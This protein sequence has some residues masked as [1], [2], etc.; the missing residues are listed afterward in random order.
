[1]TRYYDHNKIFVPALPG[2]EKD[3]DQVLSVA[4]QQRGDRV[5]QAYLD[6]DFKGGEN[7]ILVSGGFNP[8]LPPPKRG[9]RLLANYLM[10]AYNIDDSAILIED[11]ST[12]IAEHFAFSLEDYET[13]FNDVRFGKGRKRLAIAS[14][15]EHLDNMIISGADALHVKGNWVQPLPTWLPDSKLD[16]MTVSKY[17]ELATGEA[18]EIAD[19]RMESAIDVEQAA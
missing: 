10:N 11:R 9:A 18:A 13:F 4:A 2:V 8:E 15:P 17:A 6:G 16:E 3:G 14:H 19:L 12:N 1:M 5:A 7:T